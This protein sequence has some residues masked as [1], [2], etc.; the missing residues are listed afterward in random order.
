LRLPTRLALIG[1]LLLVA[2]GGGFAA[3]GGSKTQ[4]S[5]VPETSIS[6]PVLANFVEGACLEDGVSVVIDFGTGSD[7]PSLVRCA[8]GFEG[9]GWDLFAAT[10]IE[11]SGTKQYPI[12]FV[13][14]IND[15]PAG[16]KQNCNDTPTYAEGSWSYFLKT[17]QSEIWQVS[18]VGSATRK[19]NCGEVEGWRFLL[20]GEGAMEFL[21][22]IDAGQFDC[23][24]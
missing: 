7:K 15:Y 12:G 2:I 1:L 5:L 22:S 13:C 3:L 21:P 9:S 17:S 6:K 19:P 23:A 11:V 18:G 24:N 10:E 20:P 4:D 14:R 16:E 8:I